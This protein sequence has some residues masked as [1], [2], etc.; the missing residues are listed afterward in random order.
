MNRVERT[1]NFC[2][3]FYPYPTS[4]LKLLPLCFTTTLQWGKVYIHEDSASAFINS[5]S[6]YTEDTKHALRDHLTCQLVPNSKQAT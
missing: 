3:S 1:E 5:F 2:G 4:A 6:Y